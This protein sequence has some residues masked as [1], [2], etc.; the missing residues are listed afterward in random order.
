[1][2]R[3]ASETLGSRWQAWPGSTPREVPRGSVDEDAV[4]YHLYAQFAADRQLDTLGDDLYLDLPVGAHPSGFDTW[5]E[6]KS[7]AS[8]VSGGAPPDDFFSAGQNWGFRPLHPE[9]IRDE[10]YRY[11]IS[12]LRHLMSHAQAIRIDHVM[13]LHRLWWVPDGMDADKGAYVRYREEELRALVVLEAYRSGTVVAG[14]DL[15]T[16]PPEVR[17]AMVDDGMLSSFVYQFDSSVEEPLPH[18]RRLTL[19]SLG[20]HDL[21]TF[22]SYWNG[23]DINRAS[24]NQETTDSQKAEHSEATAGRAEWRQSVRWAL[25]MDAP[26]DDETGE[27]REALRGLLSYLAASPAA[28][29]MVDLEDLM[30]ET[31]RQ[32][33]PGTAISEG[34]FS[35]RAE[36]TLEAMTRDPYVVDVLT[37]MATA[38]T[39]SEPE[40]L[41]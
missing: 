39:E 1:M 11:V 28:L 15:G 23:W 9:N 22:R 6:P 17:A 40:E 36:F 41:R 2:F 4:R 20:T 19:A 8:S 5:W 32:N 18:P 29:V 31:A 25:G 27:V 26:P 7:F 37:R 16:V 12:Y 33:T 13:G 21:P 3:S 10:E 14:E 34:N 30:M 38:R 24:A 35:R